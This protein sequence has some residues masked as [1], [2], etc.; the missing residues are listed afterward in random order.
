[1]Q[2][3]E[4]AKLVCNFYALNPG[5]SR[6]RCD[7]LQPVLEGNQQ[8]KVT[9]TAK[10]SISAE[11]LISH[12][13]VY[14]TGHINAT[15]KLQVKHKI[16]NNDADSPDKAQ[17]L[18]SSQTTVFFKIENIG[19]IELYR[20]KAYH[21]PVSPVNSGWSEQCIIGPLKPGQV[22][23]CKRDILLSELGLNESMGRVQATN[24]INS[25]TE[26]INAAN[27]TYFIVP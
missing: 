17:R 11:S 27:P 26:V 22:R 16:N 20:V 5:Q 1:M 23:Y 10:D 4:N 25:A 21:D 7:S 18:N 9:V 15:G 19:E 24:A 14:Y 8:V 3:F 6:Q 12:T 2:V 13:D